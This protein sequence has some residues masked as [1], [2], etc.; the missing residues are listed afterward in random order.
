MGGRSTMVTLGWKMNCASGPGSNS[1]ARRR[2]P[3]T[4]Y[5]VCA[6]TRVLLNA[7]RNQLIGRQRNKRA[8]TLQSAEFV[9]RRR[10]GW[11]TGTTEDDGRDDSRSD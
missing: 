9:C 3:M 11:G 2:S 10:G 1:S 7:E 8:T 4:K 5:S 6:R